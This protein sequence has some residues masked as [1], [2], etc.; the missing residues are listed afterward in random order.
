MAVL[1]GDEATI[2]RIQYDNGKIRLLPANPA[3]EPIEVRP[4][5]TR[6]IGKVIGLLRSYD[7]GLA[8]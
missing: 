2:K 5:E 8:Y 6:V 7:R 1:I 3:Y 4:E